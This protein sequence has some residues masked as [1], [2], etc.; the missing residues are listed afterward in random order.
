MGGIIA[1]AGGTNGKNTGFGIAAA[2]ALAGGKTGKV[3]GSG[4][5]CIYNGSN[6][7]IN[8]GYGS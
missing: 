4:A 3:A 1:P 6:I 5:I 2:I 7:G 8:T